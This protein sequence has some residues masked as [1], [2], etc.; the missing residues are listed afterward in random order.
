MKH[1]NVLLFL[2][3]FPTNLLAAWFFVINISAQ[4]LFIKHFFLFLV[5]FLTEKIK[6]VVLEKKP[7]FVLSLLSVNF[8]R[9]LACVLF[10]YT[11]FFAQENQQK[12]YV[13]NFFVCYF[14]YLFGIFFLTRKNINK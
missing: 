11:T 5:F 10:L 3:L 2:L 4:E 9:I 12:I 7:A 13:Y 6:K 14:F 8:L 1:P